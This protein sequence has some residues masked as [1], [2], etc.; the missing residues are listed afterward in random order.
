M[1]RVRFRPETPPPQLA[2]F[3]LNTA[4]EAAPAIVDGQIFFVMWCKAESEW[5]A[6]NSALLVKVG[7]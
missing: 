5:K 2:G 1:M 7:L 3:R 4:Y 6:I